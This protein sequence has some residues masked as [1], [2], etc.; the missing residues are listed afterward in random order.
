MVTSS[1]FITA[2]IAGEGDLIFNAGGRFGADP[3]VCSAYYTTTAGWA[4]LV[5][6][7]S[8]PQFDKLMQQG[9]A[10]GDIHVR[11]GIYHQ[12]SAILNDELPSL[13]FMSTSSFI[14]KKSGLMGVQA[15]SDIGYLTW[16][17]ADWHW[18]E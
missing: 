4:R 18:A 14:G 12:A 1:A 11:A 15:S 6:G 3:S 7:Y 8:N 9:K 5:M 17:I 2:A 10:V 16:N 13:F